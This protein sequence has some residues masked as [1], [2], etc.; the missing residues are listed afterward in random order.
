M[1]CIVFCIVGADAV[2]TGS[3]SVITILDRGT[4][5]S[6]LILSTVGADA[7][8]T[9]SGSG[10]GSVSFSLLFSFAKKTFYIYR[11]SR[12][13]APLLKALKVLK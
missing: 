4:V 11:A 7:I 3:G 12:I 2:F 13:L 1:V 10:S 6:S 8:F 5:S 9:G